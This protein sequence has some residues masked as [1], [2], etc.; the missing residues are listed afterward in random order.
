VPIGPYL[1]E[2]AFDPELVSVMAV[3]FE[4]VYKALDA[5]GVSDVSKDMIAAKIIDLTRGGET[6]PVVLREL[7]LSEFGLSD[8]SKVRP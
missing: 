6:D 2:G 3:A 8:L 5:A 1:K 4:D 7:A